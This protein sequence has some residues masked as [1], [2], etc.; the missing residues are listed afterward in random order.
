VTFTKRGVAVAARVR[1]VVL[2]C[3]RNGR[4]V[5]AVREF[6]KQMCVRARTTATGLLSR[7]SRAGQTGERP[8]GGLRSYRLTA[9]PDSISDRNEVN[10]LSFS[11]GSR[12]DD[13]LIDVLVPKT[14]TDGHQM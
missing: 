5:L 3:K 12:L 7:L 8:A 11:E 9:E 14:I 2:P 1:T 6:D 4:A 10:S 13:R